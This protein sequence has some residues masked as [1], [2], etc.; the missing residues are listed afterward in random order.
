MQQSEEQSEPSNNQTILTEGITILSSDERV[1]DEINRR[2]DL[3]IVEN[4]AECEEEEVYCFRFDGSQIV[5]MEMD[6]TQKEFY[7]LILDYQLPAGG[8]IEAA[9]SEYEYV[10]YD[11][12]YK[13]YTRFKML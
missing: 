5:K 8:V 12:G 10:A 3:E 9:G 7:D 13:F 4:V 6:A 1:L 11:N 2:D